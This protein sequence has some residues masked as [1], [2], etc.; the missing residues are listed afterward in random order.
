MNF[1][2]GGY[3]RP[4]NP[5]LATVPRLY[6]FDNVQSCGTSTA[7]SVPCIFSPRGHEDSVSYAQSHSN[8]VDA[9]SSA[10]VN[11]E[12]RENNS[13]SKGVAIRVKTVDFV[14]DPQAAGCDGDVCNDESM[15][16]GLATQLEGL[17]SNSVIVFHD[18]GSHGPA[19]WRRYPPSFEKFKPVCRT[20]ELWTCS[21]EALVN[22]YDNTILYTDHVLAQQIRLLQQLSDVADSLLI[23]VSD[24]GE[25]LGEHG[26]YLHGAPYGLAPAEQTRVPLLIWASDGYRRRFSLDESCIQNE[27]H[28]PLTHDNIYHTVLGAIGVRNAYY[29]KRLDLLGSCWG[30][31]REGRH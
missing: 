8:L 10:G 4:T 17:R 18:L 13:N 20:S 2:L 16:S 24:H 31:G 26:L 22:T 5:E 28:R 11:V 23:Y 9:L 1:Q 6:Y 3:A 21:K 12:W 30:S 14:H 29:R 27:L 25:S 19:Y 7:V 15:N